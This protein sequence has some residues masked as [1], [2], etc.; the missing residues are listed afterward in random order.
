MYY[1]LPSLT[2]ALCC[3]VISIVYMCVLSR[4]PIL[5]WWFR[6]GMRFERRAF[7]KPIWGC[8]KCFAGQLALWSSLLFHSD[9]LRSFIQVLS[10]SQPALI[11]QIVFMGLF[12][13]IFTI[14]AAVL[15]T[16]V[17]LRV[18]VKHSII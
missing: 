15:I 10:F 9:G 6:F 16:L 4:E 18:L 3:A 14:S 8:E 12:W 5:N 1:L 7:H 13:L 11:L 17:L 2:I